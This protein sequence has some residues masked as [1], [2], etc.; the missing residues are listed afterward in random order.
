MGLTHPTPRKG[1]LKSTSWVP[2]LKPN[3]PEPCIILVFPIRDHPALPGW[4]IGAS[5]GPF[6]PPPQKQFRKF[7]FFFFCTTKKLE[8]GLSS[9]ASVSNHL[10]EK[11]TNLSKKSQAA[12]FSQSPGPSN[13][14]QREQKSFLG[15]W[16]VE[17]NEKILTYPPFSWALTSS[18]QKKPGYKAKCSHALLFS[19]PVS[20]AADHVTWQSPA[21]LPEPLTGTIRIF[22]LRLSQ[23]SD[24]RHSLSLSQ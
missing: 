10:L 17:L 11:H 19:V 4:V 7:S 14:P 22:T 21:A 2:D 12:A 5:P 23:L 8:L 24:E 6:P 15:I 9:P 16:N 13:T 3:P 1:P 18:P 20:L